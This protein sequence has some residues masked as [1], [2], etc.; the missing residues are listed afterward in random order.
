MT[1]IH[2]ASKPSMC[3]SFLLIIALSLSTQLA[4]AQSAPHPALSPT[5]TGNTASTN[6]SFKEISSIGFDSNE[7]PGDD[8][9]AALRQHFAF[10]GYWLN[11]PPGSHQNA[12]QGRREA[13]LRNGFG[14]LILF[15]GRLDAE[16]TQL[17][18]S[19]AASP[20]T[21]AATDAAEAVSA[22]RREHFPTRAIIFLDQEE[23]GRLTTGQ[24]AYL[25]AWTEAIARSGYLPGVYASGQPVPDGP[26]KTITAAGDIQD[27]VAAQHLHPIALWVYQDACPPANGCTLHPPA[28]VSSGTSNAVVWQYAQSPRRRSITKAC[29]QTY[30]PDG[31]CSVSELPNLMLDLNVAGSADP[32]HGR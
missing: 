31:N 24:A 26:R 20:A 8:A 5:Q 10:A 15:N 16:I 22:A 11:P 2:V 4:W 21:L 23:G 7:Y 18:T 6:S 1:N 30:A 12:W 9:L 27:H 29:A 3:R 13:L 17:S 28:L 19:P 25:F 14:F 32:S